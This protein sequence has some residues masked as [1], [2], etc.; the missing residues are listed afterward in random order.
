MSYYDEIDPIGEEL[1]ECINCGAS[2][3]KTYCG[4]ECKNEHNN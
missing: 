2:T 4:D 3:L 1:N